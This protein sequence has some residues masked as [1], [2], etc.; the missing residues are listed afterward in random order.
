M[1]SKFRE[2]FDSI[3]D[4]VFVD[5]PMTVLGCIIIILL[6]VVIALAVVRGEPF[7]NLD[8]SSIHSI[9]RSVSPLVNNENS[10]YNA[11]YTSP[12][13]HEF[14]SYLYTQPP[15]DPE[16]QAMGQSGQGTSGEFLPLQGIG[17]GVY[18][19]NSSKDNKAIPSPN[20]GQIG[21]Q[22]NYTTQQ[23]SS[24]WNGFNDFG[25]PFDTQ[26]GPEIFDS[27]YT[28]SYLISGTNER[29]T[30]SGQR[31]DSTR[32]QDWYPVLQKDSAGFCVQGSDAMVDCVDPDRNVLTCDGQGAKRFLDS[33]MKTRWERLLEGI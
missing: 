23:Y 24:R 12:D 17:A 14:G 33:K 18:M 26:S 3:Y 7:R 2:I 8:S 10:Q 19:K 4:F 6:I 5:Y 28:N 20:V 29:V 15:G 21:G 11:L 16:A 30:N 31:S 9:S 1:N 25:A 32:C 22:P 13:L 27:N